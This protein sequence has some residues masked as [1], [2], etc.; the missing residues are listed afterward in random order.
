[1]RKCFLWETLMQKRLA[2]ILKISEFIYAEIPN[3]L[4]HVSNKV[5]TCFK[6]P[7]NP[8]TIDL[9]L[10]ISVCGF[11]NTCVLETGLS[12]FHKTTVTVL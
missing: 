3:M 1:M 7:D 5:P 9:I 10:T 4:Q 11:Q 6:H 2:F 12:E 8:K